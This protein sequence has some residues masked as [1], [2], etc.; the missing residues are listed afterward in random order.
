MARGQIRFTVKRTVRVQTQL[1]VRRTFR[2][3]ATHSASH[4]IVAAPSVRYLPASTLMNEGYG[5]IDDPGRAYDLFLSYAGEDAA[6]AR[7]LKESLTERQ[8]RVWFAEAVLRPGDSLRQSIDYGLANSRFGVVL[9]SQSFFSKPWP[10]YEL[11][12]LVTRQMQGRKVILPVWHRDLKADDVMR[13][14]PS[15]ADIKGLPAS[16]MSVDEIADQLAALVLGAGQDD[17]G[18]VAGRQP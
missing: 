13:Y 1:R 2:S 9:F 10:N 12:G 11:N 7:E 5:P 18:R 8:L 4:A 15:L 6:F 3:Y 14:S 17:S 16:S